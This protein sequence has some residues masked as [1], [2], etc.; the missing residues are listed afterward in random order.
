MYNI[1]SDYTVDEIEKIVLD[2]VQEALNL[3]NMSEDVVV[4]GV[5]LYGSRTRDD[6]L[7]SSDLDVLVEYEG[8]LKEYMLFNI[9][10]DDEEP[11]VLN[12][13]PVDI[14]PIRAE[15]SG[16]IEEYYARVSSF[17]KADLSEQICS[18][19]TKRKQN[20]NH[21]I[22]RKATEILR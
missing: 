6:F 7:E 11:C 17:R 22:D 19:D 8:D 15:E 10:H 14:N 20:E 2:Y 9:L 3:A 1:F 13:I 12:D 4:K 18:A 16:T 21:N 5:K